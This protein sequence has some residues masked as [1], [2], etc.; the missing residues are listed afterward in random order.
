MNKLKKILNK[1]ILKKN[2]PEFLD[3]YKKELKGEHYE[4]QKYAGRCF[5]FDELLE[6]TENLTNLDKEYCLHTLSIWNLPDANKQF[7]KWTILFMINVMFEADKKEKRKLRSFAIFDIYLSIAHFRR[8]KQF[9][10]KK[11]V[12]ITSGR[13]NQSKE[14]LKDKVNLLKHLLVEEVIDKNDLKE[15]LSHSKLLEEEYFKRS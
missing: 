13:K 4:L 3:I 5:F 11:V 15:I 2:K 7:F 8:I 6:Q 9:E 14:I 12:D 10:K 1:I